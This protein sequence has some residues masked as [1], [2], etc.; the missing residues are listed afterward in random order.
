MRIDFQPTLHAMLQTL[1]TGL[2]AKAGA[3]TCDAVRYEAAGGVPTDTDGSYRFDLPRARRDEFARSFGVL[4]ARDAAG[5]ALGTA[6]VGSVAAW[7][8]RNR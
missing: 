8:A 6:P 2:L 1:L 7:R 3:S 5:R 4:T